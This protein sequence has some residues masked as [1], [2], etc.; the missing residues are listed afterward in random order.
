MVLQLVKKKKKRQEL[1][2][3]GIKACGGLFYIWTVGKEPGP[4]LSCCYG[5]QPGNYPGCIAAVLQR[6][7]GLSL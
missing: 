4:D 2:V 7:S 3:T 5:K 6:L 1:M